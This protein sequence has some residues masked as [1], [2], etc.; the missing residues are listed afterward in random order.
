MVRTI[1]ELSDLG[2]YKEAIEWCNKLLEM[3]PESAEA[4]ALKYGALHK[5]GLTH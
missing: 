5:L 1:K 2:N 3:R 4:T